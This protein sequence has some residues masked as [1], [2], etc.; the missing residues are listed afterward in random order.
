M[1]TYQTI[2]NI[3]ATDSLKDHLL[4][5]FS[6]AT[7]TDDTVII[8]HESLSEQIEALEESDEFSVYLTSVL[9]ETQGK[10]TLLEFI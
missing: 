1:I 8:D 2:A 6:F 5:V 9:S 4:R 3:P 7:Q 10:A